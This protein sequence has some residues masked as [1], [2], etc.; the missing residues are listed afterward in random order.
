MSLKRCHGELGRPFGHSKPRERGGHV[1]RDEGCV[2]FCDR[3]PC[4][5]AQL[6]HKLEGMVFCDLKREL[7]R[8]D[9]G[10]SRSEYARCLRSA[11]L[12]AR[13]SEGARH[14]GTVTRGGLQISLSSHTSTS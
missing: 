12:V 5:R 3:H 11:L 1:G 6:G 4:E 9:D 7:K 2:S 8:A 10:W 14:L 13:C